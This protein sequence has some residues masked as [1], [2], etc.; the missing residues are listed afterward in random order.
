MKLNLYTGPVP[1]TRHYYYPVLW[2]GN[3]TGFDINF[4]CPFMDGEP[5]RILS[6]E[7][8]QAHN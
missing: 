7:Y 6:I 8:N 2:W 1:N 4:Q 5:T 3:F